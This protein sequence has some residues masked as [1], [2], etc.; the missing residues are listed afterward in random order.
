MIEAGNRNR[1]PDGF[2][3]NIGWVIKYL[4]SRGCSRLPLNNNTEDPDHPEAFLNKGKEKIIVR[5]NAPIFKSQPYTITVLVPGKE[6]EWTF[7]EDADREQ[8]TK[9]LDEYFI[10][11][12]WQ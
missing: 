9:M 3:S 1:F 12:C 6:L 7:K 4:E 8:V 11:P 5:L 10:L 2:L